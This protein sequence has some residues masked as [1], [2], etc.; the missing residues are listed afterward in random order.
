[1]LSL[2]LVS[3]IVIPL[4]NKQ[5]ELQAENHLRISDITDENLEKDVVEFNN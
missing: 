3:V 4:A 2:F 1:M 5:Q